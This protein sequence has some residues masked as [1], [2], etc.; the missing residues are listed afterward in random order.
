MPTALLSP[1]DD[2]TRRQFLAVLVG[3]GLVAG[4]STP[5]ATPAAAATRR[6]TDDAGRE[7]DVP[8]DPRRVIVLDPNRAAQLPA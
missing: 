7:V 3:A 8:A 2:A 5:S 4:C 1:V 6:V